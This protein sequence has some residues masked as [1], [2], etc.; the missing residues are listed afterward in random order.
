MPAYELINPSDEIFFDAP[1]LKTATIAVAVVGGGKY[2]AKD[3]DGHTAVPI[4]MFGGFDEW[5]KGKFGSVP[6]FKDPVA[7]TK[8][9]KCLRS[10][11]L[12]NERSS[13]N[14]I[15]AYAKDY[16]DKIEGRMGAMRAEMQ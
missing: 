11:R 2:A 7:M 4:F 12:T 15:C 9:I 5:C 8:V 14:D 3:M 6:D 10:F 1:D 16:A 13:M